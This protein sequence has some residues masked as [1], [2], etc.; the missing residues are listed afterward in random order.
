MT[1]TSPQDVLD[2][3]FS[4]HAKPLWFN[5]TPGFDDELRRRFETT[6]RQGRDGLLDHWTFNP[7]GALA[8]VIVLDQFPLNMYRG[9][10]AS[11]STAAKALGVAGQAVA[12]AWDRKLADEERAFLY[13][14]FMHSERLEDQERSVALFQAAGL[15][16]GLH[17]ARHHHEL[18]RRFGRFPHRNAVLGR[19]STPEELDYLASDEAFHG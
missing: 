18:I 16:D 7:Q 2:H 15:T 6:W 11:Y 12:L 1:P 3:W 17:W 19:D 8:L 9:K 13:L 14:P 5:S 10:P 4:P